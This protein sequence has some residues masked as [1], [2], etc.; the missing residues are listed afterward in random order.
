V[1]TAQEH[2]YA[3]IDVVIDGPIG[4]VAIPLTEVIDASSVE[5]APTGSPKS[6]CGVTVIVLAPLLPAFREIEPGDADN[7]NPGWGLLVKLQRISIMLLPVQIAAGGFAIIPDGVRS[8]S[9]GLM[10][11][12]FF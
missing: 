7:E 4:R 1:A 11:V 3:L 6:L 12:S 9:R 10:C 2:S 8:R 5:R